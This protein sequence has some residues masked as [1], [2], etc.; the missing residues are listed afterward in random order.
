MQSHFWYPSSF[1]IRSIW[2]FSRLCYTDEF[3]NT[4]PFIKHVCWLLCARLCLS[5]F[6]ILAHIPLIT[7]PLRCTEISLISHM[8]KQAPELRRA[9]CYRGS[10]RITVWTYVVWLQVHITALWHIHAGLVCCILKEMVLNMVYI[11]GWDT[12]QLWEGKL[13]LH[14]TIWVNP[15]LEMDSAWE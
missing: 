1:G 11:T 12:T 8:R 7:T 15:Q 6:Q 13:H 4:N 9:Q 5:A 14:T 2:S 10:H 3:K